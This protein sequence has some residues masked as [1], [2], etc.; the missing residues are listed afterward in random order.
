MASFDGIERGAAGS[1]D[2]AWRRFT[3][4]LRRRLPD[5]RHAKTHKFDIQGHEGYITVGLYEDGA[6]GELVYEDHP[7]GTVV[8]ASREPLVHVENDGAET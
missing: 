3:R 8:K 7:E 6:P 1:S 4:W 5:T 2:N